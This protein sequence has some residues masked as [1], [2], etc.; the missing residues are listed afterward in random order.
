MFKELDTN[1]QQEPTKPLLRVCEVI[2]CPSVR[3]HNVDCMEFMKTIPDNFYDLAIVDPPYGISINESIG[4]RKGDKHSGRKKAI[5]DKQ[6]PQKQYFDEL[7]RVSKNQIIWGA[8]Y[9][10]DNIAKNTS[11]WLMWDKK[12]S[13]DVTFSQF[14]MAWTSFS[15][16]CKKYDKS[17]TTI[18]YKFHPTQK[19]VD[20]YRWLL[21]NYAAKGMKIL[22]TH[23]GSMSIAIACEIEGFDLD[24]CEIDPEYFSKGVKAFETHVS[25][26]RL[27]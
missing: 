10:M 4:R 14:E 9:F 19:P 3:F 8:N 25:Q 26:K 18:G 20:L 12:F 24:I 7:F 6:P 5:W 1:T 15:S 11:C 21:Q 27:F 2:G 22:D 16:T 13:F 17:P 23:G